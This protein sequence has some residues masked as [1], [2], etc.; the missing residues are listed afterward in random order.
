MK[1]GTIRN[2]TIRG[3]TRVENLLIDLEIKLLNCM[4]IWRKLHRS[5]GEWKS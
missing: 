5:N 1:D 2:G 3:E 4:N